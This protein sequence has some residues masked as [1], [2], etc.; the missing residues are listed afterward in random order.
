MVNKKPD[1]GAGPGARLAGRE[2]EGAKREAR[3]GEVGKRGTRP[4]RE[5]FLLPLVLVMRMSLEDSQPNG[6][7]NY[8]LHPSN[9][10]GPNPRQLIE[11]LF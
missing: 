11:F 10:R 9:G 6:L 4:F 7:P 5:L 1:G 3:E 8:I 2:H